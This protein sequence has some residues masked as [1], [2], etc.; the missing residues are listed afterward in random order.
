MASAMFDSEF[1]KSHPQV[2]IAKLTSCFRCMEQKS[3][4]HNFCIEI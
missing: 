2:V 3:L 4:I 1:F